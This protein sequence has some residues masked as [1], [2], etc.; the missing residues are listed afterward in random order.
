MITSTSPLLYRCQRRL[1]VMAAHAD[2]ADTPLRFL[3]KR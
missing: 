1:R 3:Q 2:S